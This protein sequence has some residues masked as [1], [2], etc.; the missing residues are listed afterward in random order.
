MLKIV[1]R[2]PT[3]LVLKQPQQTSNLL[4]TVISTAIFL[5]LLII[6]LLGQS[7]FV[8]VTRIQCNRVEADQVNCNVTPL[9]WRDSPQEAP[10]VLT[11]VTDTKIAEAKQKDSDGDAYTTYSVTLQ[12]K[13][14]EFVLASSERNPYQELEVASQINTFV[15]STSPFMSAT[16]DNR[17]KLVVRLLPALLIGILFACTG[18]YMSLAFS[19][20]QTYIFA[21]T[22]GELLVE[23]KNFLKTRNDKYVLKDIAQVEAPYFGEMTVT[24][25]TENGYSF[26]GNCST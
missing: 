20:I 16:V 10:T 23:T 5:I 24:G 3:K 11:K 13:S 14:G 18:F 22:S 19:T 26:K 9:D 6:F 8:T 21:Q 12:S 4:G 17:A 1:E 15:K 7:K 25:R 2:S